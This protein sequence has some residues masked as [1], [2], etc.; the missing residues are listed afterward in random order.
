MGDQV[1]KVEQKEVINS[2]LGERMKA[3]GQRSVII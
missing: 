2:H 1:L 3:L